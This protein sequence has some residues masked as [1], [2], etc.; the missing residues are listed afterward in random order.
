ML[1]G[2]TEDTDVNQAPTSVRVAPVHGGGEQQPG[3]QVLGV[4]VPEV[5]AVGVAADLLDEVPGQP[6]GVGDGA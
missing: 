6:P 5:G 3:E 1:R 4:A 2:S